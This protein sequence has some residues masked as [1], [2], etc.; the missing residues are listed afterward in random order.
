MFKSKSLMSAA[1]LALV[2]SAS[3]A[4]AQSAAGS[5]ST[6]TTAGTTGGAAKSAAASKDSGS[7]SKADAKMMRDMAYSNIAEVETGK[8]AQSKTK[9]EQVRT[10]AQKMI[11]DHS[12]AQSELQQLAQSKGVTLP[13]E[14]DAKHKKAAEKLGKLNGAA[15]DS[16]YMKQGGV[17]DH[18]DAHKL[19]Q[20]VKT[21]ATDPDLKALGDK[22]L[23]V[24][25]EHLA[26]AKQSRGKASS[27]ATGSSATS[28]TS[29]QSEKSPAAAPAAK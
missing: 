5:S 26:M 9:N 3:S 11:D 8:L 29:G 16:A 17:N 20:R 18:S 23:P 6:G 19:V 15:F 27:G 7:V 14:P 28:G 4:Y 1:M 21:K 22:M 13:T 12:K 24:I 2:F 25:D 10:F